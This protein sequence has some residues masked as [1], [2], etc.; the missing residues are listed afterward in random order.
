[1]ISLALHRSA[2]ILVALISFQAIP[3]HSQYATGCG[4]FLGD[5]VYIVYFRL[6]KA[7]NDIILIGPNSSIWDKDNPTQYTTE[8][9]S[10]IITGL[11]WGKFNDRSQLI[12]GDDVFVRDDYVSI[13]HGNNLDLF[14][15]LGNSS[16]SIA[17]IDVRLED[18]QQHGIIHTDRGPLI[19]FGQNKDVYIQY[20][21]DG[22]DW[23]SSDVHRSS[24]QNLNYPCN[25]DAVVFFDGSSI[26]FDPPRPIQTDPDAVRR[27][28]ECFNTPGCVPR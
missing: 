5:Q 4:K 9:A 23:T 8:E 6:T 19:K 11:D 14:T 16:G 28:I 27:E 26:A 17:R 7:G 21:F 22:Q 10:Y 25:E 12:C 15:L 3:A 1:M 18:G 2:I 24:G 20:C 13:R